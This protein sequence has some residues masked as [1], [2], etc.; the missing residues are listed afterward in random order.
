MDGRMD[1]CIYVCMYVCVWACKYLFIELCFV[2]LF[3]YLLMYGMYV[4][5]YANVCMIEWMYEL[6]NAC[7]QEFLY[8]LFFPQAIFWPQPPFSSHGQKVR[9]RD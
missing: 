3:I 5:T 4:G 6:M 1:V 2:L 7:T 9:Y 8:L